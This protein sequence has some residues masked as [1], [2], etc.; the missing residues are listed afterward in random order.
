VVEHL[1]YMFQGL[2]LQSE[3]KL[4]KNKKIYNTF[5][6]NFKAIWNSNSIQEFMKITSR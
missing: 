5:H 2:K 6:S 4:K 3:L 1:Q